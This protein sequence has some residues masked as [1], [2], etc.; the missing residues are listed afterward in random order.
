MKYGE[1]TLGQMEAIV[2]KL[3]GMDG[4]M[5]F[6]RDELKL[7][8]KNG[9]EAPVRALKKLAPKGTV[10]VPAVSGE[11][12]AFFSGKLGVKVWTSDRFDSVVKSALPSSIT[13]AEHQ[14]DVFH[15]TKNMW[16]SEIQNELGT[17]EYRSVEEAVASMT[18]RIMMWKDGKTNHDLLTNGYAN[19]EHARATDGRIV[20][21]FC[22][23]DSVFGKWDFR[24][25]ELDGYGCWS[26]GGLFSSPAL[27]C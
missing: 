20:A 13:C 16:D 23:F 9:K 15:L 5:K 24:C 17:K 3:G 27:G 21:V 25:Y 10:T 14:M 2:N 18:S 26:E 22:Y 1:L 8:A 12:D 11:K 7:V 4:A 6:L 19:I